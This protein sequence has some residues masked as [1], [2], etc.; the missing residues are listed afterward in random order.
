MRRIT[1]VLFAAA[2]AVIASAHATVAPTTSRPGAYERYL[3]RVPNES[4]NA[5]VKV[6]ITFPDDMRVISFAD[7][8]GWTLQARMDSTGR[9]VSATWTGSLPPERFVEFPFIGVN[10]KQRSRVSWPVMQTYANG[11]VVRWTGPEGS[12]SPASVTTIG[13]SRSWTGWLPTALS[14][15]ALMLAIAVVSR[16]RTR[17]VVA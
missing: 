2:V 1:G 15:V 16:S 3:L 11:Q 12:D 9:A 14:V 6:E 5:T 13:A 10:P 17:R 7:V 8:P 4:D